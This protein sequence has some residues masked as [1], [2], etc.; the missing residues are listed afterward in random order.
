MLRGMNGE[1]IYTGKT[2]RTVEECFIETSALPNWITL[3]GTAP[4]IEFVG[5]TNDYG[6]IRVMPG[7]TLNNVA[8][9]NVLPSGIRLDKI[10]EFILEIDSL[11]FSSPNCV[12][13]ISLMNA[14]R[15][16]GYR[17]ADYS[18]NEAMGTIIGATHWANG[19]KSFRCYYDA[20]ASDEFKRRRNLKF[21][22]RSDRTFA[23]SEGDS[24]FAQYTFSNTEASFDEI[25]YP[26]ISITTTAAADNIFKISRVSA[27]VVHN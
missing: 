21:H 16:K 17:F 9:L 6:G 18:T 12:F 15:T 11:V 24:V 14:A 20:L 19:E 26:K 7:A 8:S 5:L 25:L 13:E 23:M 27:T 2:L 1:L 4:A 22:V 10:K 3:T